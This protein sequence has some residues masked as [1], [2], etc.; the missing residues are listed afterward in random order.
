[1]NKTELINS[2]AEKAE[3]SKIDAKKA[4]E[5]FI[6]VIASD[7][8]AGNKISLPGFGTF[9]VN[10][11]AE[12]KGINPKTKEAIT[13]PAHNVAKFKPSNELNDSLN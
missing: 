2:I 1:M 5:A 12:R 6:E 3:L 11:K 8:K 9:S 4:V 10:E 13:I 7:L